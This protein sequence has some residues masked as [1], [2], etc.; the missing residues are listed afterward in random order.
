MPSGACVIN[1]EGARGVVWKVKYRDAGGVQ[2]KET[3]GRESE[4]VTRKQGE[5]ALRDRLVRVEQ[6]GYVKPK[7]RTFGDYAQTWF[8]HGEQTAGWRPN[9][10]S[11]YRNAVEA[12]LVPAFGPLRLRELRTRDIS[13]WVADVMAKAHGRF[14]RPLRAKP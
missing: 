9:T 1:Y 13:A 3:I 11:V 4:G 8:E 12:H 6:K 10:I 14:N 7:P 2:V 5:V